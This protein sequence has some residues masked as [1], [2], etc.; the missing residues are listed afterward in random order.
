VKIDKDGDDFYGM[1]K[2]L[3]DLSFFYGFINENNCQIIFEFLNFKIQLF[4]KF[5]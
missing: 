2:V 5:V 3:L 4:F 1:L